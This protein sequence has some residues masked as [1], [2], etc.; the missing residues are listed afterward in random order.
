MKQERK[1]GG[2]VR[3]IGAFALGATAGAIVALLYAPA[4]GKET[5]RQIANR[6][7]TLKKNAVQLKAE[8]AERLVQ[9]RT[10]MTQHFSNG[11]AKRPTVRH[12]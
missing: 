10:W 3:T 2:I 12:A 4:S 1:Q 11:H 6:V 8:A 5:R 9:A 7:R